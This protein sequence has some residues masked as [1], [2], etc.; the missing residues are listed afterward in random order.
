M[1]TISELM[2]E[3]TDDKYF[4]SFTEYFVQIISLKGLT[5]MQIIPLG[6]DLH[7]MSSPIF[8]KK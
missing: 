5:F 7:N 2:T 6:E 4:F 8:W 1:Y 3:F